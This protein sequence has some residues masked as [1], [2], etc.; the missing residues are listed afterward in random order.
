M[1]LGTLGLLGPTPNPPA[2]T[3]RFDVEGADACGGAAALREAVDAMLGPT[4]AEPP[5]LRVHVHEIDER[6]SVDLQVS[7]PDGSEASRHL[8][9]ETC[10]A[11]L[12]ATA[13][14]IALA[15]DP[16]AL[17][18]AA[19]V[20][21]EPPA[22]QRTVPA[23]SATPSET[24]PEPPLEPPPEPPP[25]PA[26]EPNPT[27]WRPAWSVDVGLGG[28]VGVV[29][30]GAATLRAA[31]DIGGSAWAAGLGGTYE[32]PRRVTVATDA[33]ARLQ[34]WSADAFGCF[35]VRPAPRSAVAFPLCGAL[36]AGLMLGRGEG[37]GIAATS[38]S[39]PWV[40]AGLAAKVRWHSAKRIG[41][42]A[43]LEALAILRRPTFVLG[44]VGRVCCS[45][46]VAA[47]L[48]AGI[49][50]GRA[51]RGKPGRSAAATETARLRHLPKGP[52]FR[53]SRVGD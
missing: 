15:M 28:S 41:A 43:G 5:T 18:T 20:A 26:P 32:L 49:T 35:V 1:L 21:A 7:Q 6:W 31:A 24:K 53:A 50:V 52:S 44:G 33:A 11:A 8:E 4:A 51:S 22:E 30:G 45:S 14:V 2:N 16:T 48:V 9:T 40:A 39:T 29:P 46:P 34:L 37:A 13:V 36:H 47:V 17:A 12:D 19:S 3:A 27:V 25:E 42:F 10:T 23:V 38:G